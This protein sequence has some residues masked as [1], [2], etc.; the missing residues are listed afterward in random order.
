MHTVTLSDR[1]YGIMRE[2]LRVTGAK[3]T[4]CSEGMGYTRI[5]FRG[6]QEAW[7]LVAKYLSD[8]RDSARGPE[9]GTYT[10][11]LGRIPNASRRYSWEIARLH[12]KQATKRAGG[13]L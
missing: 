11:A 9:R 1:L 5:A 8:L 4:E 10:S 6:T 2:A 13:A 12:R 7:D 3:L